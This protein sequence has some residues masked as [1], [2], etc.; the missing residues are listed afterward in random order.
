MNVLQKLQTRSQPQTPAW[1]QN[2]A[3]DL[4]YLRT[5]IV[6]LYLYGQPG[7][8]SGSWALIDA[9]LPGYA[10]RIMHAAEEWIG[11]WAR[12]AAEAEPSRHSPE[13][14]PVVPST[15]AIGCSRCRRM[16]LSLGCRGGGGFTRRATRRVT[17]RCS[18]TRIAH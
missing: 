1:P 17:C 12:P 9:G 5:G 14:I 11:P 6:N 7:A 16:G 8:P 15:S 4:A 13:F 10:S 18:G 2:L 3:D